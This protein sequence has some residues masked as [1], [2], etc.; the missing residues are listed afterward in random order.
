MDNSIN[1][2]Y[3]SYSGVNITCNVID[4]TKL[5]TTIGH[6]PGVGVI[7]SDTDYVGKAHH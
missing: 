7:V 3:P 5:L 4:P 6:W 2:K 1:N